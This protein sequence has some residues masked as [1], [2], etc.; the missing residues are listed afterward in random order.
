MDKIRLRALTISDI[1]KT[2]EWNNQELISD[3]YS[4]HPFPVN[5]EIEKRLYEKV[6]T[7]NFPTTVFGIEL[8]DKKKLIGLTMLKEIDMITRSA[9]FGIM[10]GDPETRGKGY[11]HEACLKALEFGFRKLGL[12]RIYLKVHKT[13]TA[14][15]KLYEKCGF[16]MEGTLRDSDFKNGIFIDELIM[17]VLS[18]E[19]NG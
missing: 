19:F 11:A 15:L 1:D 13:N 14:A 4:G 2:L 5:L 16:R 18:G 6:L 7:S 10:I 9:K 3:R 12:H 8:R 17:S